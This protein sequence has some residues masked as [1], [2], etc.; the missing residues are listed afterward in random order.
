[1][2][3]SCDYN[4]KIQR[5]EPYQKV[6]NSLIGK[7]L[8]Y[9][10]LNKNTYRYYALNGD[11]DL[12][13][14][15]PPYLAA[16]EPLSTQ[17]FMLDNI[18][19]I[20][21]MMGILGYVD[22]TIDKPDQQDN[23]SDIVYKKRLENLLTEAKARVRQGFR[24]G[25]NVGFKEDH[26]FN[27]NSTTNSAANVDVIF[28]QNELQ[29]ASGLK[30]DAAFLGRGSTTETMVTILFTKML[31]QLTNIQNLASHNL[32]YGFSLHLRLKGFKFKYL[33][34]EFNKS[35]ITDDLKYQQAREIKQRILRTAYA[36]GIIGQ[37]QHA[38]EMGYKKPD[39]PEPRVPIDPNEVT[40]D[41]V[42]KKDRK[43]QKDR[44]SRKGT[45]KKKPQGTINDRSKKL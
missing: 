10:K 7:Y 33:D 5:Y 38:D 34:V 28:N 14:G 24:D 37:D 3:I 23:E 39:K 45:D 8:N 30:Y 20:I 4:K 40:G 18:K 21:E 26:E 16:L 1:K 42:Q 12:P 35:T 32:K 13:Y 29:V 19:F 2:N 15:T 43:D 9:V 44:S 11:T 27:F 17:K 36:D 22:V 6:N 25:I 41:A 31:S